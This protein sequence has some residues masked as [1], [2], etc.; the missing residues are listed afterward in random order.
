LD[1]TDIT[2]DD[3]L[4]SLKLMLVSTNN[5]MSPMNIELQAHFHKPTELSFS[6]IKMKAPIAVAN[7]HYYKKP[8]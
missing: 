5:R 6:D 1:A 7:I 8:E 2:T 3:K 4:C